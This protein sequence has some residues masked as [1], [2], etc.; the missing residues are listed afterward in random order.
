M[1]L[2]SKVKDAHTLDAQTL[3]SL[4]KLFQDVNP[5]LRAALL[6][7]EQGSGEV[8]QQTGT[9]NWAQL[10]AKWVGNLTGKASED[11]LCP[12]G[13]LQCSSICSEL[14]S[15]LVCGRLIVCWARS[16]SVSAPQQ[17]G[18]GSAGLS[19]LLPAGLDRWLH[20]Q[21]GLEHSWAL[22][23][24]APFLLESDTKQWPCKPGVNL[25][26]ALWLCALLDKWDV[27]LS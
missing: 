11:Y 12:L 18:A 8:L 1:K 9:E 4:L 23:L 7:R 19:P 27:F 6:E 25:Q 21:R 5:K 16:W 26:L 22:G 10:L 2:L 14:V 13:R 17:W 20:S 3:V 15:L 24:K